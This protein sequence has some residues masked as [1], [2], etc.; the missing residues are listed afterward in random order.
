MLRKLEK[1]DAPLMIEWMHDQDVNC[2]FRA[3]FAH[4]TLEQSQNFVE[5][6]FDEESQNFAFVD[7]NDEYMGTISLK[8]ISET[9]K[10]A[11]YAVV[12]RKCAQGTGIAY[13]A[14]MDILE[15][16]FEKLGLHRVYSVSY[17]HL[18]REINKKG[19]NVVG[20]IFNLEYYRLF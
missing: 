13:E 14:T 10:N 17:T 6:S 8:H 7:E 4:M 2:N 19:K 20:S 9:D 5:H 3:D 1:K 16:A 15:Y 18:Q 11:E 12:T